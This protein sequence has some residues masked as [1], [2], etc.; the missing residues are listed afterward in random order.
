MRYYLSYR[1]SP[2]ERYDSN[3]NQEVRTIIEQTPDIEIVGESG[4]TMLGAD[5]DDVVA[6]QTFDIETDNPEALRQLAE[7]LSRKFDRK[8]SALRP[9]DLEFGE[10]HNHDDAECAWML[11]AMSGEAYYDDGLADALNREAE[12]NMLGRPLFPN[13]Y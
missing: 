1:Q 7:W 13:E 11:E 12:E 4:G 6:D 10:D 5:Y 2:R 3:M 9:C 8:V